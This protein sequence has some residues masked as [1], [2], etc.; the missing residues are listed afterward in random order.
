MR[1]Y[2]MLVVGVAAVTFFVGGAAMPHRNGGDA[3]SS[4]TAT[5]PLTPFELNVAGL[6]PKTSADASNLELVRREQ[7][8]IADCMRQHHF[9]YHPV[10][11]RSIVDTT[12][13]T[14][15]TSAA[16][17][18]QYGFGI[19]A[20]PRFAPDNSGNNQYV[21]SLPP[22][23]QE[24]YTE[25]AQQC[26]D[27]ATD[28]ANDELHVTEADKEFRVTDERVKRD[29]RYISAQHDWANCIERKGYE[30]PTREELIA[31]L[32]EKYNEITVA[33]NSRSAP[34]LAQREQAA[35]TDPDYSRF[36]QQEITTAVD[37]YL[38]SQPLDASY[39]S[40]YHALR[41]Q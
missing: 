22:K 35:L 15:F 37:T 9:I 33:I 11:P 39:A 21:T 13:E 40:I 32:R 16:Y 2:I 10:E 5:S 18:H 4:G 3:L 14:D 36:R 34:S 17:A 6:L 26:S 7:Q 19:S 31:S 20:W 23:Q 41:G 25:A 24:N 29:P 28:R 38:C 30:A 12:T 27:Q 8:L 1:I